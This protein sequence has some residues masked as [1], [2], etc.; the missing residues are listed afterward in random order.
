MMKDFAGM[1]QQVQAM[2]ENMKK[3]QEEIADIRVT[4]R[5]GGGLVSVEV[6]GAGHLQRVTID[7][8]LMQPGERE[9]LEDLLV[10]AFND[11][12]VK[13]DAEAQEKMKGAAGGLGDMLPPGMKLPF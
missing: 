2:Q 3:A 13:A 12:K 7:D 1:M 11:A 5:S 4:G 6:S 9:V 8:S 10:A